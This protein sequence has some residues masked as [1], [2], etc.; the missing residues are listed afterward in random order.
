MVGTLII[1]PMLQLD[2]ISRA[3]PPFLLFGYDQPPE[4]YDPF[5]DPNLSMPQAAFE[6]LKYW[7]SGYYEHPDLASRS[8]NSLNFDKRGSGP[9]IDNMTEEEIAVNFDPVTAM[10]ELPMLF[11]MQPVLKILAQTCL[12]DEK[13]MSKIL[14][15]LDVVYLYCTKTQWYC[16]WGMIEVERQYNEHLKLRHK[17]RP[18]RFLEIEGRNHFV[19]LEI[20][21]QYPY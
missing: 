17:V 14:P 16:L 11:Q 19:S 1:I 8:I 5:T 6:N 20:Y 10:T 15:Q 2:A 9:S 18:I 7:V 12:F 4:G 13:I 3:E 21:C